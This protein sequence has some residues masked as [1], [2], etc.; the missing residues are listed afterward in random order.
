MAK[1][2]N[3]ELKSKLY[4][5][6]ALVTKALSNPGRLEILDLIAQGPFPVEYIAENTNMPIANASQHLQVLKQS[7]LVEVH[8]QGKYSFYQ[9]AGS[10]VL[11]TWHSLRKLAFVLN[12]EIET[13]LNDFR[14]SEKA[15]ELVSIEQ[16][17]Q[18]VNQGEA[19]LLDVRPREEFEVG[20]I[21]SA[22]SIPAKL[23]RTE[24]H[25]LPKDKEIIVY[26]RGPLCLM[27]D[28][29]VRILNEKGFKARRLDAG[30]AEW[31]QY[32]SVEH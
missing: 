26:C 10:Q 31:I 32:E 22:Q 7:G 19:L 2:T 30:F 8:K 29:A 24:L 21:D 15:P 12:P 1:S 25:Q 17:N 11:E 6:L 3:R 23:L 4:Q 13:L 5:Q 16:I 9:L 20:H 28:E 18:L 27:A 14:K